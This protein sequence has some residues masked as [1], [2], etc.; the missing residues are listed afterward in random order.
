M[1]ATSSLAARETHFRLLEDGTIDPWV[2]ANASYWSASIEE[3]NT[4]A[5]GC[6]PCIVTQ[7]WRPA[8]SSLEHWFGTGIDLL[9]Q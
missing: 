9:S 3:L 4:F 2:R 7:H 1:S 5:H 6:V 8:A